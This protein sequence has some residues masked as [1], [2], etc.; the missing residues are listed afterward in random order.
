MRG[1]RTCPQFLI[2]LTPMSFQVGLG[3]YIQ[4]GSNERGGTRGDRTGRGPRGNTV[5][6]A[7]S[8]S[9]A[10]GSPAPG[11]TWV[12]RRGALRSQSSSPGRSRPTCWLSCIAWFSRSEA[13]LPAGT[14]TCMGTGSS[15][16]LAW[17]SRGSGDKNKSATLHLDPPPWAPP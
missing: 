10:A 12:G 13:T 1:T 5:T 16:G 3:R 2:S 8:R 4:R 6:A 9:W 15:R 17:N 14:A 7:R 11:C